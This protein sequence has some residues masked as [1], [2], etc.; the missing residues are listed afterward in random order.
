MGATLNTAR[1]M[2]AYALADRG[3]WLSF[4]NRGDLEVLVEGDAR[5]F[6]PYG[7]ILVNPLRHPHVKAAEAR[8][9]IA[10]LTGGG[11]QAAIASF[12]LNG[13][14]LFTPNAATD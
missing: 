2:A 1:A 12:S 6:N 5:L 9:F 13:E 11:G 4:A 3:T 10:W 14:P 7:V 8:A